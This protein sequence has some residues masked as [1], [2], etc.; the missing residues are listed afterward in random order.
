MQIHHRLQQDQQQLLSQHQQLHTM[1]GG[2]PP[3]LADL[4][5]AT[6][7]SST[8][9]TD[10]LRL[11]GYPHD[12]YPV[13]KM[14]IEMEN[15]EDWTDQ[16]HQDQPSLDYY[17]ATDYTKPK[18][19]RRNGNNYFSYFPAGGQRTT[20]KGKR[21]APQTFE[22]I[23]TQ[24]VTANIRERQRTQSLNEAFASLR[25]IIPT[26]PSDKLSKIQT[27][28]LASRYIVFLYEILSKADCKEEEVP[29]Q[30]SYV[31]HDRLSYAFSVWRMEGAW[32]NEQA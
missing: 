31:P 26:L 12:D 21:R 5:N 15:H 27:L 10:P 17:E 1:G 6:V 13:I 2:S 16:E 3:H 22:D 7:S 11:D 14:E 18:K 20:N 32:N 30:S 25:K 9:T 4:S 29:G 8:T 28:K 24:R 23:K 19:K